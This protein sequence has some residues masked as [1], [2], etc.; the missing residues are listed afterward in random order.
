M[1]QPNQQPGAFEAPGNPL[2]TGGGSE[3]VLSGVTMGQN[4]F[5]VSRL[6]R[7]SDVLFAGTARSFAVLTLILLAGD[8]KSVV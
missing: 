4:Q 7:F 3:A 2:Y 8:R 6:K 5:T 1:A